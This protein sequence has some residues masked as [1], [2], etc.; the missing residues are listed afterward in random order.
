ML[1]CSHFRRDQFLYAARFCEENIWQL[2]RVFHNHTELSDMWVLFFSNPA[3]Q[4]PLLNQRAA[5]EGKTIIW[6]YHVV[7][8]ACVGGRYRI[9]DFDTRLPFAANLQDYI[10]QTFHAP[11]LLP[12]E[13]IPYVRKIPAKSYLQRFYSDRS[14]MIQHI[15]QI[16]FP[17]WPLI[18]QDKPHTVKLSDYVNVLLHID[19]GSSIIKL[20]S[21]EQ[22]M[23]WLTEMPAP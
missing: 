2:A 3:F 19:D 22:L 11:R 17:S 15:A 20:C 18:N 14:H 5:A 1:Q 10:V 12:R 13:L 7:L 6:D 9:F 21:R 8:L 23:T 16:G 4:V